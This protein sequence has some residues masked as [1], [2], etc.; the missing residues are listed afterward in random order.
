MPAG[1]WGCE[2]GAVVRV[3]RVDPWHRIPDVKTA[4]VGQVGEMLGGRARG[5]HQEAALSQARSAYRS[6]FGDPVPE[7]AATRWGKVAL[8][9]F[10]YSGERLREEVVR[11]DL[12]TPLRAE[13]AVTA[14]GPF[15][16][17]V[18]VY[19]HFTGADEPRS[20]VWGAPAFIESL[21]RFALDWNR[22]CRR[23]MRTSP[24]NCTLQLGDISW[25]DDQLPDPLGHTDHHL[26]ACVDV[27]LF[28]EDGSRYEAWWDRPDD[29]PGDRPG[30][31]SATTGAFLTFAADWPGV[32][33]LFFND[34][35]WVEAVDLVQARPGH[36]DHIHLCIDPLESGTSQE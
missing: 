21:M 8:P 18:P 32:S 31:S 28:R 16:D 22:R 26:G 9:L 7:I 11:E 4:E 27:R 5:D 24:S 23:S 25:Y 20:D 17:G 29:R 3:E 33:A 14:T 6:L 15:L 19:L 36:D 2:D 13:K 12:D 35:R 10:W 34:P 1:S 30:Y